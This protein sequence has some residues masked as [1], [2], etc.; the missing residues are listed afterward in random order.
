V[1]TFSAQ[2]EKYVAS[3][4]LK[5]RW[6][7]TATGVGK[8]HTVNMTS[9]RNCVVSS[10]SHTTA[11]PVNNTTPYTIIEKAMALY[12][13]Q[14]E[15]KSRILRTAMNQLISESAMHMKRLGSANVACSDQRQ[16]QN[17]WHALCN[18]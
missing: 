15:N 6:K 9:V 2:A 5:N 13:S 4:A 17:L 7:H 10:M 3:M 12:D 1:G 18:V 11:N 14:Q 16:Y 8:R